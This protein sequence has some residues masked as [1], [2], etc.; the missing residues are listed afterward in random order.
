MIPKETIIKRLA[1]IKYLYKVA[2]EQS[3]RPE[4]LSSASIL[5]FHDAVE[6]FLH[7]AAEHLDVWKKGKEQMKFMDYWVLLATKKELAQKASMEGLNNARVGLKH[8][9]ILPSKENI[10]SFRASTETFFTE[11]TLKVFEIN[12]SDISLIDLVQCE[13]TKDNLNEAEKLL[14]EEKIEDA[15]DK[16]AVAFAQLIDDYENRKRGSFGRSPF[17]FGES[18]TF[19]NSFSIGIDRETKFGRELSSFVDKVTDSVKALQNAVKILSLGLD[20]RRYVKFRLLTPIITKVISGKYYI[21]RMRWG[22]KGMPT[23]EDV[24]SCIDF[25]I[26]SAITLQK[27]DFSVEEEESITII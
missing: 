9:G 15:L 17:F 3:Q 26:E 19:L 21:E 5:T 25:V 13:A 27:F 4:P 18:M 6:L 1:F 10:D 23:K 14:K 12:F 2:I 22:T 8:H 20:Y 11:N 24:M 16:V 7:L